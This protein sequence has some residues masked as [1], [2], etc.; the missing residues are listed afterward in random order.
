MHVSGSHVKVGCFGVV[1]VNKIVT[2]EAVDTW[3]LTPGAFDAAVKGSQ[4]SRNL[5]INQ[6]RLQAA[7]QWYR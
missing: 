6:L 4:A 7:M 2:P 5:P 1:Q 3:C